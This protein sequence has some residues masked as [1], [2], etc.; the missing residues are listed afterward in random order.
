MTAV[1]WVLFALMAATLG[2]LASAVFMVLNRIDG[3]VD[4]MR[5][6][7]NGRFDALQAD[8]RELRSAVTHLDRRLTAA[9]G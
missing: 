6:E 4:G 8:L 9:G 3:R 5:I 7:C 1:V 2:I